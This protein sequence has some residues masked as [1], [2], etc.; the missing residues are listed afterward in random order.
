M[1][2]P[3][4]Y[5]TTASDPQNSGFILNSRFKSPPR[6]IIPRERDRFNAGRPKIKIPGPATYPVRPDSAIKFKKM[7]APIF[8][9]AQRDTS[10]DTS[11][12]KITPGPGSYRF[13]SDFGFYNI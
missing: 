13:Q 7:G 10:L 3:N 12:R 8:T 11:T 9:R 4:A 1:P 2:G 5:Y 6:I